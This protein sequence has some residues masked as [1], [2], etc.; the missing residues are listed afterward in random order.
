MQACLCIN[1]LF[2]E[3]AFP[4]P[5]EK[6]Q[7]F[8]LGL[9]AWNDFEQRQ[10]TWRIEEVGSAKMLLKIF[11]SARAQL[12]DRNSRSVACNEMYLV[13]ARPQF[14]QTIAV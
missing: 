14:A 13:C 1:Y 7:D 8:R 5:G 9:G 11:G 2:A 10:V 12:P 4:V 6:I 3:D